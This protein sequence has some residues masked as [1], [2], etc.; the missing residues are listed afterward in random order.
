MLEISKAGSETQTRTHTHTHTRREN[1][2]SCV[3][4]EKQSVHFKSVLTIS[5]RDSGLC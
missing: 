3:S 4:T 2:F 5:F 1:S